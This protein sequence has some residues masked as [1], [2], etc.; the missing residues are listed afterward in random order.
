MSEATAAT[1]EQLIKVE[2]HETGAHAV[3]GEGEM[4]CG[5]AQPS[6]ACLCR[7]GGHIREANCAELH[8]AWLLSGG[9]DGQILVHNA[10]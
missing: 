4:G 10:R 7:V 9:G 2:T 3:E 6:N 5:G 1:A 8:G